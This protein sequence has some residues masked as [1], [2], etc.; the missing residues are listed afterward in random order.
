MIAR[1]ALW[2][3]RIWLAA[4][5]VVG[6]AAGVL[7]A[8]ASE[9]LRVAAA[10]IML[11]AGAATLYRYEV[12]VVLMIGTLAL[13]IY[14]RVLSAPVVVTVFHLVLLLT[15]VS[16]AIALFT[17]E[18]ERV[19]FSAID[20]GI[21]AL[22]L[23]ALWS[24]PNSLAFSTTAVAVVRLVALW[25]FTLLYAN[26][27]SKPAVAQWTVA[28]LVA[29][30]VGSSLLAIAQYRLPGF[31]FGSIR[32][33]NEGGGVYLRRVGALF[34]DPNFFATFLS[35]AFVA[36]AVMV[37]HSRGWR[38]G[39]VW[40]GSS[41]VLLAGIAVSFSRTALVGVAVAML[42]LIAT[43][44]RERRRMLLIASGVLV[45][46]VLVAAPAQLVDRIVSIGEV[47]YNNSNATRY[48]MLGPT[49]EIAQ[50]YW[51]FGTGLA[52]FDRAY[53]PYRRLGSLSSIL[54]PHQLPLAMV[55]EMG[56]AG[57]LAELALVGGV[58]LAL[59]R[60]R[61]DGWGRY[62]ALAVVGLTAVM[63]QSLFQ[64]YLYLEYLWLLVAFAASG[65]RLALQEEPS[66]D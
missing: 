47:G 29:T 46:L 6:A 63:V 8:G 59:W 61:P 13:D 66:H 33:I 4:A 25:A 52:A 36:A 27:T 62:E 50:D 10:V 2:P 39:V 57:L 11:V 19:R 3:G 32:M 24:L 49:V 31:T 53:P 64:Y 55:A 44:P 42:V 12:G 40:A 37:V 5:L 56:V 54:K 9:P 15:L 28:A 48:Y 34:D 26:A 65:P 38:S 35:V 18:G 7:V 1:I 20:V 14:G 41:V 23:A 58:V 21:G 51:V 30:G 17:R 60:R 43:A 22:V 16:W 45:A